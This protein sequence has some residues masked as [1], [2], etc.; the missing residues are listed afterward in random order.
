MRYALRAFDIVSMDN[1]EAISAIQRARGLPTLVDAIREP[2]P[3]ALTED[4]IY[5]RASP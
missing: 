2:F 4:K 1:V 5:L 3:K